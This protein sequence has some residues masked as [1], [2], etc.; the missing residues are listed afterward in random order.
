M[1]YGDSRGLNDSTLF[2]DGDE[3]NIGELA[4]VDLGATLVVS[5]VGQEDRG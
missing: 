4:R 5:E 3:G 1:Y 2:N